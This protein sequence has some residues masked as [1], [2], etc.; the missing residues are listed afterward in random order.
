MRIAYL[1]PT[2]TFSEE[3]A[4]AQARRDGSVPMPFASI[5]ALVSAVETG[6]ADEAVLP[7]ENSIEGAVSTTLDLLIHETPLRI[8]G[9]IVLPV[10]HFLVTAPGA[11]LGDI[12]VVTSHPQAFGQTRRFL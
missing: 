6:L 4:L 2:G 5:P 3:A 1:G 9:E 10:R 12:R 7:I 8:A 11:T